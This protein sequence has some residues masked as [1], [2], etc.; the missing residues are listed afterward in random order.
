MYY[1]NLPTHI[2]NLD[3]LSL[4]ADLIRVSI[5]GLY[6]FVSYMGFTHTCPNGCLGVDPG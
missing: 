2:L 6:L 1:I 5:P 4:T 3:S